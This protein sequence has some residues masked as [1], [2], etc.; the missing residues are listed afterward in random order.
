MMNITYEHRS[1]ET[2][3][4]PPLLV[5]RLWAAAAGSCSPQAFDLA[6]D[7]AFDPAFAI[8]KIKCKKSLHS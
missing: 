8:Q 1:D 6:F 5:A 7:L 2:C 3:H 4:Q